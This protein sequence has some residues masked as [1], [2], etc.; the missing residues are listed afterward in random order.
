[1]LK[2]VDR[3]TFL[4]IR[5]G[6][7]K[8]RKA[9]APVTKMIHGSF[10]SADLRSELEER[11]PSDFDILMVHSSYNALLPM[12]QG[13]QMELLKT[14]IDFCGATRTLVM[15]AFYFGEADDGGARGTF[16]R[17]PKFDVRRTPSQMGILTELFRRTRGV[18]QSKHPVYRVAALG[19]QAAHLIARHEESLTGMGHNTPFDFM[20]KHTTCVLG[21]GKT[22]Q[23]LT[24]VHHVESMLGE[25]FPAETKMHEPIA[26][27]V[28]GPHE[29][30][31]VNIGGRSVSQEFNIWKLREILR[32]DQLQ[33][34]SFHSVPMFSADAGLVTNKLIEAARERKFVLYD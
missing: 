12:Y 34:W 13:S 17:D 33:E 18:L 28:V 23:V 5:R 30:T 31:V 20:A 4:K 22:F 15:P 8:F 29:E 10:N 24:Q 26:V 3:G 27:T 14:L 6:Y 19:P 16:L 11:L 32:A 9:F 21:V 25:D 1:L 2:H 7:F